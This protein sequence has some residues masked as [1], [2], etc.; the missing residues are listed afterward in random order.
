M[1]QMGGLAMN[2]A[3]VFLVLSFALLPE[4]RTAELEGVTMAETALVAGQALVL[5][6]LGLRTRIGFRVYV[7]GL[8]L[9]A[10]SNDAATVLAAPGAKRMAF[11]L[12]RSVGAETFA[13]ALA[14]G[15]HE[16]TAPEQLSLLKERM[17]RLDALILSLKEVKESDLVQF[18][19][20]PGTGTTV[21]HNGKL[22]GEAIAG[23]DFYRAVLGVFLGSKPVQESLKAGLLGKA[24]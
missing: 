3:A 8:Y 21:T 2:V 18:D 23:D 4:A 6:G 24:G 11:A 5:N 17:E 12:K 19:F 9:A 10:K 14:E 7:A 16:N 20:S 15:V 22:V 1:N 13:K